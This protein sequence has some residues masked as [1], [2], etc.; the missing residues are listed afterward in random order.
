MSRKGNCTRKY[1]YTAL[2]MSATPDTGINTYS[3]SENRQYF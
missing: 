3:E 1:L 2:R